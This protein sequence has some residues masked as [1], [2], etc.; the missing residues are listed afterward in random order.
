MVSR[1]RDFGTLL[2]W[3]LLLSV[4]NV[5]ASERALCVFKVQHFPPQE[6][7]LHLDNDVRLILL[8]KLC[9]QNS[10]NTSCFTF[11]LLYVCIFVGNALSQLLVAC[12][13]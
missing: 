1:L 2:K 9:I 13:V 4:A 11:V 8:V 10:L 6:E 7:S 3:L 5:E 12:A